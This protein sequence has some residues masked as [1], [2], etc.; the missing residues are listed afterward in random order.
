MLIKMINLAGINKSDEQIQ[1]ELY[2]A[3]I[4]I[5]RGEKNKCGVPYSITGKLSDWKFERAWYYWVTSAEDGDGLPLEVAVEMHKRKYPIVG[6]NQPENYG[7][8]IRVEGRCNCPH[9]RKLAFPNDEALDKWS[10]ETGKDWHN[11][12]WDGDFANYVDIPK[13][14]NDGI[15]QAPRFVTT[16]HIDTQLGLNEFARAVKD[17]LVQGE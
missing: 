7:Q 14:C 10:K 2:L 17:F 3:G 15:I 1:E 16:Y 11:T 9:P 8:V 4:E 6:E 12:S 13:L 5:V